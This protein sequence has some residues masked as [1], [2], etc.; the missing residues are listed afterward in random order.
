[1][2]LYCMYILRRVFICLELGLFFYTV[3][4]IGEYMQLQKVVTEFVIGTSKKN[5]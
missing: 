2:I 4:S 3:E 5:M 1:M